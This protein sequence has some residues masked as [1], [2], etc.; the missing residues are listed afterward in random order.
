VRRRLEDLRRRL[1]TARIPSGQVGEA[2]G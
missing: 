1:L 2:A